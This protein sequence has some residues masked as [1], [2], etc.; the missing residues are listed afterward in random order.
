MSNLTLLDIAKSNGSDAVVGLIE[1]SLSA[2]PEMKMFPARTIKGTSY[3]T[4]IRTGLPTVGFRN[5]NEGFAASKSTYATK[6]VEA[7]ILASRLVCD[8]AVLAAGEDSPEV[9]KAREAAGVMEQALREIGSQ[10]WYGT[11]TDAKGFPGLKAICD[12]SMLVDA[13]GSS[14]STGSSVWAVKFGDQFVQLVF[15]NNTTFDLSDWRTESVL[16]SGGSN[17]FP[18]EVADLTTW[19]GLQC[20]NKYACGSIYDRTADSGKGLTDSLMADLLGKFPVGVRPDA[21]FMSRRSLSQLQKQRTVTLFGNAK[22]RPDQGV[23]APLPTEYDGIPIV[24]T[25][26]ITNTEELDL[27]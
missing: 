24:A 9:Y 10:I 22:T 8:I 26:S 17:S 19:V 21:F 23:I 14:A 7:Y 13:N 5:A 18:A 12:S 2:A 27:A 4:L 6:N 20:V 11:A 25:D 3:K 16:D 1:E 15:G